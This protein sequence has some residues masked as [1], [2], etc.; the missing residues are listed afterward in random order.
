[1]LL[2]SNLFLYDAGVLTDTQRKSFIILI[3]KRKKDPLLSSSY[4]PITLLN[5]GCMIIA[6]VI[7]S[8]IKCSLNELIRP[9]QNDFIKG[10]H[11]GDVIRLRFDVIDLTAAK[12][13]PGSIFTAD[14][15]KTFD[16]LK[17]DFIFRFVLKDCFG[18]TIV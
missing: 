10:R 1:M 16:S 12:E 17:W 11:I 13:I 15:F 2:R 9:G 8:K 6:T 4:R 14:T 7:N 18:S 5:Y 3:P